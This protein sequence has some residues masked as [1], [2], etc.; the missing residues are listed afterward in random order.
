MSTCLPYLVRLP[1]SS[2]HLRHLF[3]F[4]V[5]FTA[6][7]QSSPSSAN[8]CLLDRPLFHLPFF[9]TSSAHCYPLRHTHRVRQWIRC[10]SPFRLLL[11]LQPCL[12]PTLPPSLNSATRGTLPRC[13]AC[14][15]ASLRLRLTESWLPE[16][17]PLA[18]PPLCHLWPAEDIQPAAA[19]S[20]RLGLSK[21]A[22]FQMRPT[23][24]PAVP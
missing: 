7:C 10:Q 1:H 20:C 9:C 23:A 11:T 4:F 12:S 8:P 18:L 13:C 17:T 16:Q 21:T 14:L 6:H 5:S 2:S 19:Q 22:P 24:Q 15:Q 3:I